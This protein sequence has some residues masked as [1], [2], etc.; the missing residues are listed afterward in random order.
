MESLSTVNVIDCKDREDF[1][2]Q[3]ME[4]YPDTP[5]GNK[6]AEELFKEWVN[7]ALGSRSLGDEQMAVYLE[8]GVCEIGDGCIALVHSC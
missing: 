5:E 7:K 2:I 1:A 8:D 6:A 4:S 3:A